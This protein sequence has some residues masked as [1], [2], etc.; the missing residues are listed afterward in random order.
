MVEGKVLVRIK[1]LCV[2]ALRRSFACADREK[3]LLCDKTLVNWAA[4]LAVIVIVVQGKN[5]ITESS[6]MVCGIEKTLLWIQ[7]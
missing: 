1:T 5:P 3:S 7:R 2:V 4:P 6:R